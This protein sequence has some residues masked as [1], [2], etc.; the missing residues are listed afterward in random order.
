MQKV[1][2]KKDMEQQHIT[3]IHPFNTRWRASN[4]DGLDEQRR[5]A[6][7]VNQEAGYFGFLPDKNIQYLIIGSFPI[8]E[9]VHYDPPHDRFDFSF[10]Y[11]SKL[12]KFYRILEAV[13]GYDFFPVGNNHQPVDDVISITNLFLEKKIGITDIIYEVRRTGNGR[14]AVDTCLMPI[15]FNNICKLLKEYKN[16]KRIYFTSIQVETWFKEYMR[17]CTKEKQI[18]RNFYRR[19]F[20]R[21]I[22]MYNLFSP[23]PTANVSAQRNLNTD[24]QQYGNRSMYNLMPMISHIQDEGEQIVQYR[25]CQWANGLNH[26]PNLIRPEI[27]NNPEYQEIR[28]RFRHNQIE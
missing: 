9:S 27:L 12:N 21:D 7:V 1:K 20:G 19:N 28:V 2:R 22:E 5:E 25:M 8:S 16:I 11:C 4:W 17:N 14:G 15:M 23:A 13:T 6:W 26:V 24:Q 10:F 3:E 18:R